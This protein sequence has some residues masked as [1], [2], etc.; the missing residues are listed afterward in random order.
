MSKQTDVI[1]CQDSSEFT[2]AR[3]A[4]R[5]LT[6]ILIFSRS[7]ILLLCELHSR[8]PPF[9]FSTN[10]PVSCLQDGTNHSPPFPNLRLPGC[11]APSRL[12]FPCSL[13]LGLTKYCRCIISSLRRFATPPRKTVAVS[14]RTSTPPLLQCGAIPRL[15]HLLDFCAPGDQPPHPQPEDF[16]L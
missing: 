6:G 1:A 13:R 10:V 11:E 14:K 15:P 9:C 2:V 16:R 3:Q 12:H 8:Q 4:V 7:G 5:L